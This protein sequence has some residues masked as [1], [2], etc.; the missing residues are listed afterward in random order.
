MKTSIAKAAC[1]FANATGGV[2]VIGMSTR[3][4]GQ[5]KPDVI[6]CEKPVDDVGAVASSTLDIILKHV[7]PGIT[8]VRVHPVHKPPRQKSGFVLVYIPEHDSSPQRSNLTKEFY[9][10]VASGTIPMEYF[11]IEDRFGRRPHARLIVDVK[12]HSIN[13]PPMA[14]GI[15]QRRIVVTVSNQGR[16]LALFP[17]VRYQR[18]SELSLPEFMDSS[19]PI[20]VVSQADAEWVSLRGGANDVIYPNEVLQIAT[21]IQ[22]GACEKNSNIWKFPA[23]T[24]TTE[25]VCDGMASHRQSFTL[26]AAEQQKMMI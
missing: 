24:I 26:G 20:W 11:Q 22:S 16:G 9:V 14:Y 7:A 21:L 12:Q 17:A 8:G 1:G 2:I 6:T 10:R 3:R 19:P 13:H 25:A 18:M 5:D 4:S 15:L 23:I